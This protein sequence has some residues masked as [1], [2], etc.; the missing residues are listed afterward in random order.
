MAWPELKK[1]WLTSTITA[2]ETRC[3]ELRQEE[4]EGMKEGER[5]RRREGREQRGG[6][7]ERGRKRERSEMEGG[8]E[9]EQLTKKEREEREQ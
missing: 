4:R 5:A 7:Q 1:T 9:E 6:Y 8:R 3:V 2:G